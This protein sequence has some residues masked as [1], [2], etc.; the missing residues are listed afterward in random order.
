MK[1]ELKGF[2]EKKTTPTEHCVLL[3]EILIQDSLNKLYVN[4]QILLKSFLE[5]IHYGYPQHPKV[6]VKKFC[7]QHPSPTSVRHQHRYS[8]RWKYLHTNQID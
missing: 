6:V 7:L 5:L 2:L 3:S 4:L 1:R 8:P